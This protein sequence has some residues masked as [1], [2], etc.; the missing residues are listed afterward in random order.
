[1]PIPFAVIGL[2]AAFAALQV[3]GA[4]Q[5]AK[6]ADEQMEMQGKTTDKQIALAA[7]TQSRQAAATQQ[8]L[9]AAQKSKRL[10][11][12]A[13]SEQAD[14][15]QRGQAIVQGLPMMIQMVQML[16]GGVGDEMP[17]AS[18]AGAGS[19][20]EA[21]GPPEAVALADPRTAYQR[22]ILQGADTTNPL[23]YLRQ[24]GMLEAPPIV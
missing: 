2:T 13:M 9:F 22:D 16:M 18:A 8:A 17:A 10:A 11:I 14:R 12:E 21:G 24:Q 15:A 23:S 4:R 1:M 7:T 6:A 5:A 3:W 20:P 19:G